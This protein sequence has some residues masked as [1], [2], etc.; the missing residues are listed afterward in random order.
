MILLS[1]LPGESFLPDLLSFTV[2]LHK[3][4]CTIIKVET[5][6][7]DLSIYAGRARAEYC[8]SLLELRFERPD[9]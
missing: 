8:D 3:L 2:G 1:K 5:L 9:L 4:I 6:A 7:L